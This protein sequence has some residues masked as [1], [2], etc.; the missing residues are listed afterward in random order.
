MASLCFLAGAESTYGLL[1][2][3]VDP[4]LLAFGVLGISHQLVLWPVLS[5]TRFIGLAGQ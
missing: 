5:T 3:E 2:L 4:N 1:L